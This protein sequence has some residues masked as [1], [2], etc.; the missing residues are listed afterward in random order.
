[1]RRIAGALA[2][3]SLA[4]LLASGCA[5]SSDYRYRQS[6]YDTTVQHGTVL[7]SLELDADLE[8]ELL[9]LD[10][11]RLSERDVRTVLAR[12]PAPRIINLHGGVPFVYRAM[13][14]FSR[15]L[16]A[17]GYP[18]T[19]I[20]NPR[21]GS[22]SYSPYTNS[23]KI[24]GLIA[25]YYEKEGLMPILV[26]H[27]M[28]GFQAVKVLH[29]LAG[30]YGGSVPVWSPLT[31]AREDRYSILDPLT[32]IERPVV[33]LR[34]GYATAVGAG[35]FPRLL[36]NQWSLLRRLRS[37]PDTVEHF[38]GTSIGVDLLG[39]DFFGSAS[40]TNR[41]AAKGT[42]EVRNVRLPALYFH[43]I[44][45]VTAHLADSP[46]IREWINAYRPTERPRLTVKFDSSSRN[47][48]WAADVWYSIKKQWC[49]EAQRF[50][51]AKRQMATGR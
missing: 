19:R 50:V 38:T 51:R 21:D 41:Y 34:I 31:E 22:Y 48:L 49:L 12:G 33:G 36:P 44:V 20:R 9:G 26:G 46:Q 42:A 13:E 30:A 45:P 37:I 32:G 18:E 3:A 40:P 35:G 2:A 6:T 27:S 4:A 7:Q 1:V 15:F 39:G 24:A 11:E 28:G 8:Q 10:P 17:M 43:V 23:A 25:W 47:V 16:I 29:E 5:T 14:S